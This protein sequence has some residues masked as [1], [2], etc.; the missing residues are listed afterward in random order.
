MIPVARS[1][2]PRPDMLVL[3]KEAEAERLASIPPNPFILATEAMDALEAGKG[4]EA[5][6]AHI[7]AWLRRR[8]PPRP[9]REGS[10][11]VVHFRRDEAVF[12]SLPSSGRAEG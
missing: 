1:L 9:K 6:V 12:P 7:E 2:R 11:K 3:A 8:K 10:A 4:K 5:A